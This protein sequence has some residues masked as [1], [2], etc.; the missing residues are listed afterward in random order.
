MASDS[1]DGVK[2]KV[3]VSIQAE[4]IGHHDHQKCRT[5]TKQ[6][7]LYGFIYKHWCN[8]LRY[9]LK[10]NEWVYGVEREGNIYPNGG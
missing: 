8:I 3:L 9:G 2:R 6:T 1:R 7:L 10:M 4:F 5:K